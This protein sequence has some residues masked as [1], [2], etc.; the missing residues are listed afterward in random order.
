MTL[1][2]KQFQRFSKQKVKA[3][4]LIAYNANNNQLD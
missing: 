3:R 2:F 4:I 1:A